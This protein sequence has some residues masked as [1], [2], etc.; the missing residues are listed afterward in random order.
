MTLLHPDQLVSYADFSITQ[1]MK[2]YCTALYFHPLHPTI[3]FCGDDIGKELFVYDIGVPKGED[4]ET[5]CRYV[6]AA[7]HIPKFAIVY[8]HVCS[9][10][11]HVL[12]IYTAWAFGEESYIH[13]ISLIH[14]IC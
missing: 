5:N 8:V 9:F 3:L 1:S 6:P 7:V 13:V 12:N 11:L 2:Q 10:L 14:A 4:Y